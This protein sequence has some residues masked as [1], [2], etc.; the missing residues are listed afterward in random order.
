MNEPLSLPEI[1]HLEST[2]Q[3]VY[4]WFHDAELCYRQACNLFSKFPMIPVYSLIEFHSNLVQVNEFFYPLRDLTR[5][6]RSDAK[7]YWNHL[8]RKIQMS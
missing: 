5:S 4:H 2:W 6:D 3:M 7:F 8:S 1:K